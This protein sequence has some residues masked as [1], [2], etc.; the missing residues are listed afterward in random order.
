MKYNLNRVIFIKIKFNVK[1]K[2]HAYSGIFKLY[3]K[4]QWTNEFQE[5]LSSNIKL[6]Q[7]YNLK[8]KKILRL[9]YLILI[10]QQ[11]IR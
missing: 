10:L 9:V 1:T 5:F 6:S 8:K 11:Q 4:F 2:K 3:L 7:N